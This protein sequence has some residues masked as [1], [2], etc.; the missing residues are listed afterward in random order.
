MPKPLSRGSV[1]RAADVAEPVRFVQSELRIFYAKSDM[2]V[3][4]RRKP[5]KP[6]YLQAR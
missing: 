4:F 1:E 5:A 3:R 6:T 2:P